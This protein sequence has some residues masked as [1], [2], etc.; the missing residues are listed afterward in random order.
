M[1]R[2]DHGKANVSV[3]AAPTSGSPQ[4]IG[5]QVGKVSDVNDSFAASGRRPRPSS[6]GVTQQDSVHWEKAGLAQPLLQSKLKPLKLRNPEHRDYMAGI[7][8]A[9]G[10]TTINAGAGGA[11]PRLSGWT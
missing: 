1:V 11:T 2:Q 9:T 7:I 8:T 4:A 3:P 6:V 5:S 10:T